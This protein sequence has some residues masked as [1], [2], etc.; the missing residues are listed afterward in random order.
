MNNNEKFSIAT[1]K[2]TIDKNDVE[3][4]TTQFSKT[5][6]EAFSCE[7]VRTNIFTE[8]EFLTFKRKIEANSMNVF[9][10]EK[11]KAPSLYVKFY[12]VYRCHRGTHHLRLK[13][14]ES[15]A[16]KKTG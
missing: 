11:C 16:R 13:S 10:V 8:D 3:Y 5:D 2:K 6:I 1:F 4:W 12:K 14:K 15:T 7:Y 9:T